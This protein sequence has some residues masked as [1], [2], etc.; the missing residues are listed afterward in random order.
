MTTDS[1]PLPSGRSKMAVMA[2]VLFSLAF[3]ASVML[4]PQLA[5]WRSGPALVLLAGACVCVLGSRESLPRTVLWTGL[6]LVGWIA[7]RCMTA[8]VV[9]FALADGMLLAFCVA[10]FLI[11]GTA[12]A[13][14][15]GVEI[16]FSGLGLL[17][18]ANWVPM[19]F[20]SRDSSYVLW[21]P[22][23]SEGFPSGFFGYYGDCA[24]FLTAVAL[25]AGGLVWDGRRATWFRMFM[26]VVALAAAAGVVFTKT[27]GGM[28]GLG[29]GGLV[30]LLAPW[31]TLRRGSRWRGVMALALP[32]IVVAGLLSLGEGFSEAQRARGTDAVSQG[33]VFDDS[34]RLFWWQLAAS[35]IAT[36]PWTG[37]G[38]RSFSWENFRFWEADRSISQDIQ[39]EFVHNEFLQLT[40]DYGIIGLLLVVTVF[41]A[42][43]VLG[44]TGRW[45][46]AAAAE[47][48]P[49][50][51]GGIAALAGLLVH[52]LFHFVFHLPPAALVLGLALAAVL[53]PAMVRPSARPPSATGAG[54]WVA[55][56]CAMFLG[57]LAVM[58]LPVFRQLAPVAYRFGQPLP[59]E[60]GT[61]A[62][63]S[64]AAASWPGHEM[65]LLRANLCQQMAGELPVAE[66]PALL[67]AAA[68]S[69]GTVLDRHPFL[70][71]ASVNRA[72]VL[73]ALGRDD[74]AEE[75][76]ARAIRLQGGLT[77]GFKAHYAASR[78]HARRAEQLRAEGDAAGELEA[79]LQA[80]DR[81]DEGTTA[82]APEF[83]HE[84]R[85]YR[86]NLSQ[87]LGPRLEDLGRHQEAATEYDRMARIPHTHAIHFLAA[88]NLTSWGDDLWQKRQP[89]A[90]MAKFLQARERLKKCGGVVPH[91]LVPADFGGL[92]GQIERKI[93]F[94]SGAGIVPEE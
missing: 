55:A 36:H 71:Q 42:M 79:L 26:G 57:W 32:L 93:E 18:L 85:T 8:P 33:K 37:G 94:L 56:G 69:F 35:G 58:T 49:L 68:D 19:W 21:L 9:E 25:L 46:G 84:G 34:A 61:L 54:P 63:V 24:A 13:S 88:R 66:R 52:G 16:V 12:F 82:A 28:I 86:G 30:L 67:E 1:S 31:L 62:R 75:E 80:R 74:E 6:A 5:L 77:R 23:G 72:N 14:R 70:A 50:L 20:Q 7:F 48:T 41:G 22:R 2:A 15:G 10:A 47:R 11:G 76:Y 27:R 83:G 39:P 44:I 73:S 60:A 65:H 59:D 40:N 38:S 90:A 64:A 53:A 87:R 89:E 17:V 45:S 92:S 43:I 51:L 3:A 29:T 81:F 78:H 91:G 4:G